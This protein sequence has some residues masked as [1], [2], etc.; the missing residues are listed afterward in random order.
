MYFSTINSVY[1]SLEITKKYKASNWVKTLY[2]TFSKIN[3]YKDKNGIKYLILIPVDENKD[4]L[5]KY[6]EI[7]GVIKCFSKLKK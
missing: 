5:K 6:E 7:Y 3:G 2:I 4:M 1:Y